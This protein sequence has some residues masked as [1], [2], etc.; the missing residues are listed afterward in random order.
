MHHPAWGGLRRQSVT[1]LVSGA[2]NHPVPNGERL[3]TFR[4]II[5]TQYKMTPSGT[6]T[7]KLVRSVPSSPDCLA[8]VVARKLRSEDVFRCLTD[9]IVAQGT[10]A[11][12]RSDNGS[13]FAV[14][15]VREWLGHIGVTTSSSSRAARGRT[16]ASWRSQ[17]SLGRE[18]QLQAT[19]RAAGGR[20]VL[21]ARRRC[22]SSSGD[23]NTMQSGR[24]PPSA[25]VRRQLT[26]SCRQRLLCSTLPA[27]PDAG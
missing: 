16:V 9:L 25:I 6:V 13:E 3:G 5:P 12:V 27:S 17:A 18:S 4:S 15:N 7:A 26:R 23:G 8:I 24:I 1:S 19:R 10:P 2:V 14:C 21:D 22:S 20:T 11:H